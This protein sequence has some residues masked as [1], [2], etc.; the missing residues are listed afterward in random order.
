M[1]RY[2]S[3]LKFKQEANLFQALECT[4]TCLCT[5]KELPV[6]VEAAIALQMLITEQDKGTILCLPNLLAA[7][8]YNLVI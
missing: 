5:D 1:L 8:G 3:E 4:K 2:F 7:Q 6:R